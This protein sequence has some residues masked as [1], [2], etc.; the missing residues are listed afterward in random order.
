M[1]SP[2]LPRAPPKAVVPRSIQSLSCDACRGSGTLRPWLC[3]NE[4]N[5]HGVWSIDCDGH[6]LYCK[7]C[8]AC[9]FVCP[10]C[11]EDT[12]LDEKTPNL[13]AKVVLCQF[14]GYDDDVPVDDD[15]EEDGEKED[16]DDDDQAPLTEMADVDPS[17][18]GHNYASRNKNDVSYEQVTA[19]MGAP[20]DEPHKRWITGPDGGFYHYWRCRA[21]EALHSAT[22]K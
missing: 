5:K 3:D 2:A 1:S 7:R 21:C 12:L 22:D 6:G 17:R 13:K 11:S 20:D 15:D 16:D 8:D 18:I 14:L 10:E 19:P 4:P 9:Y